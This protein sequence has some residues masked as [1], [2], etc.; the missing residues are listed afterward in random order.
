MM[1]VGVLARW[2]A[3]LHGFDFDD[4]LLGMAVNESTLTPEVA[5]S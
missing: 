2:I 1:G 4:H 5:W 3:S